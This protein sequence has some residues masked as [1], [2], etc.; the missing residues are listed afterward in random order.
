MPSSPSAPS[1]PHRSPGNWLERSISAARGAISAAAKSRTLARSIS[2]SSPRANCRPG[3]SMGKFTVLNV[4]VNVNSAR[5]G[6]GRSLPA[7]ASVQELARLGLE[8]ADLTEHL[9]DVAP[10]AL[11]LGAACGERIEELLQLRP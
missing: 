3:S 8:D 2:T 5:S 1:F 11:E 10:L 9:V 6:L 4:Y 7:A